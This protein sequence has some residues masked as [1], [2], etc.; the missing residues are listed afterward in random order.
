HDA[1]DVVQRS[2]GIRFRRDAAIRVSVTENHLIVVFD[3]LQRIGIC[4]KVSV[5]MADRDAQQL[6]FRHQASEWSVGLL[7]PQ[8]FKPAQV[9]QSDIAQERARQQSGFGENLKSIADA[10]NK[11][12]LL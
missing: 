5:A 4:E 10:D 6:A 11:A 3:A 9:L 2:V 1:G 8:I 7:G 12:A